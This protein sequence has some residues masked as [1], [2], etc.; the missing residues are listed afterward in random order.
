MLMLSVFHFYV[1]LYIPSSLVVDYKY[2]QQDPRL[3]PLISK[4]PLKKIL[5]TN[6]T[7]QHAKLCLFLLNIQDNFDNI[8]CREDVGYILKPHPKSFE[9]FSNL[10]HI[11]DNDKVVF[12]EDSIENLIIAKTN[13]NWITVL[14]QPQKINLKHIDFWFPD[15]ITAI[16]FF[17]DKINNK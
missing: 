3:N 9:I 7:I 5:Y 14:I 4:L 6:G 2:L 8:V 16:N 13:F 17:L 12:F 1:H 10:S 15:I 11:Y